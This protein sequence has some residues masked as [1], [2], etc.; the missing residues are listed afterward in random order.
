MSTSISLALYLIIQLLIGLWVSRKIVTEDDF[1]LA[2][3]RLG[4]MMASFSIFATW[5]GAETCIGASAAIFSGGLSHSRAEPFG[6]AICLVL[7]S[8]FLATQLWN[9]NVVTLADLYKIRFNPKVEKLA[10]YLLVPTSIIWA[11][12]QI[13]AFGQI[14]SVVIPVSLPFCIIIAATFVIFYTFMGGMMGDVIHD[15]IQGTVVIVGLGTLLYFAI[16]KG[17]GF[18]KTIGSIDPKMLSFKAEGESW[19]SRLDVWM[20]PILGSLFTQELI[21]RVLASKSPKTAKNASMNAAILYFF[22]GMIPVTLGLIGHRFIGKL[23]HQDQFLPHLAKALLPEFAFVIF[24]GALIAA[25]L[26]TVDSALLSAGAFMSRNIFG[27]TMDGV[28]QRRKVFYSRLIIAA[29]GL[30]AL[31]IALVS[32]GI[33]DLVI[34]ASSF[35]A[36]GVFVVTLASLYSPKFGTSTAAMVTLIVGVVATPIFKNYLNLDAPFIFSILLCFFTFAAVTTIENL[37]AGLRPD[38][39]E[40]DRLELSTENIFHSSGDVSF[41]AD[42]EASVMPILNI[43][44]VSNIRL[45]ANDKSRRRNANHPK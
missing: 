42:S 18:E 30:V 32:N 14:V 44:N 9:R 33:Y 1:F 34:A 2:G 16:Q 11:A 20:I 37:T 40:G 13:R 27:E 21:S 29:C 22:V 38:Y 7:M 6:S 12:A 39:A 41:A 36:A 25:I 10:A 3:R 19:L 23:E 5:F 31:V 43:K 28:D 24:T 45:V 35:G 15:L 8:V 26:S 4:P 17:G